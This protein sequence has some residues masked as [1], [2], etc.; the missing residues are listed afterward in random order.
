MKDEDRTDIQ[1]EVEFIEDLL[2]L[3]RAEGIDLNTDQA[4]LCQRH[5]RLMLRWNRRSNL[6]RI[7]QP[8]AILVKHLLDSLLPAHWLPGKGR[9]IDVGTGAGFPGIPLK[10]LCPD[11]HMLLLESHGKKVSFLK[12]LLAELK[13]E[14]LEVLQARWEDLTGTSGLL[15]PGSV[16]LITVRALKP[17]RKRFAEFAAQLLH[18]GGILAYWAGPDDRLDPSRSSPAASDL[19]ALTD[20]E[21]ETA[22]CHEYRLH[23]DYG[24]RRLLLWQRRGRSGRSPDISPGCC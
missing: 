11:L 1:G 15:A 2:A 13:L 12:V 18:P 14:H 22:G 3:C 10:I 4:R 16:S 8:E 9:A 21:L 7:T 20:G 23:R 24:T 17:A 5:I 6:T 19:P